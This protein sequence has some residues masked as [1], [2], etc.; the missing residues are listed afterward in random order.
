M[1]PAFDAGE[2]FEIS[3]MI[4]YV[5]R[6]N[7][8]SPIEVEVGLHLAGG[9]VVAGRSNPVEILREV[10]E[11]LAMDGPALMEE[12]MQR[13]ESIRSAALTYRETGSKTGRGSPHAVHRSNKRAPGA[14]WDL[15]EGSGNA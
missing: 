7:G 12:A 6:S 1:K 9:M 13:R 14:R 15:E 3:Q 8:K 5:L 4:A 11:R 2:L 10:N